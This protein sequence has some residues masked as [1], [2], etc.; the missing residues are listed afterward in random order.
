MDEKPNVQTPA[1]ITALRR[2]KRFCLILGTFGFGGFMSLGFLT[3]LF[4]PKSV[5]IPFLFNLAFSLLIML[6]LGALWGLLF[7]FQQR[8]RVLRQLRSSV[9][10]SQN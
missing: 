2:Y 1:E 4:L 10:S 9:A 7:Y 8:G 5:H 6:P 3:G